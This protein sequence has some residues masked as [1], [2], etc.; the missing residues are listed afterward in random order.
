MR[1]SGLLRALKPEDL[2]DLDGMTVCAWASKW[3]CNVMWTS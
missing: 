3:L 1:I 2:D